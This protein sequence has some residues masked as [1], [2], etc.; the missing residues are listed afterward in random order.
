[1]VNQK[2]SPLGKTVSINIILYRIE[3]SRCILFLLHFFPVHH[4]W[5]LHVFKSDCAA[6]GKKLFFSL[7]VQT[8]A[9]F[10]LQT[11]MTHSK[12]LLSVEKYI[13]KKIFFAQVHWVHPCLALL[14]SPS[15]NTDRASRVRPVYIPALWVK[16]P[17]WFRIVIDIYRIHRTHRRDLTGSVL[18]T[19]GLRT[20]NS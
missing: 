20:K 11:Q 7:F 2:Q 4:V 18:E 3:H 6:L 13:Y 12:C 5:V 15:S 9:V 10:S 19:A 17:H 1:M 14:K 8:W 16:P